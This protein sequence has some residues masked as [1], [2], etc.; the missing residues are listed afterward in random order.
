MAFEDVFL[1]FHP[2]SRRCHLMVI[3]LQSAS[4][5]ALIWVKDRPVSDVSVSDPPA[6]CR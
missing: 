5:R 3:W 4:V 6:Q 2:F 1:F